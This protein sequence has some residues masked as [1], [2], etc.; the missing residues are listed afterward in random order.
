M[1][2]RGT[3]DT[4]LADYQHL[5]SAYRK[6]LGAVK[7]AQQHMSL[8]QRDMLEL[9]LEVRNHHSM[10]LETDEWDALY[11][12]LSKVAMCLAH[13]WKISPLRGED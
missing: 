5:L 13:V 9:T 1:E 11:S 2:N 4:L 3:I 7:M 12:E 8:V 10:A 6:V